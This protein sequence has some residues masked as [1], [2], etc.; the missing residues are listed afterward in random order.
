MKGGIKIF[1]VLISSFLLGGVKDG[2]DSCSELSKVVVEERASRG[3]YTTFFNE[4]WHTLP[5]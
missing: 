1:N 2:P 5:I 3:E 4:V